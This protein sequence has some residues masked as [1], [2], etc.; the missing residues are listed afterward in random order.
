[1]PSPFPGMDPYLENSRLWRGTHNALIAFL[2]GQLNASLPQGFSASSEER[3]YAQPPGASY[4]PDDSL[5]QEFPLPATLSDDAYGGGETGNTAVIK[6]SAVTIPITTPRRVQVAPEQERE[7]FVEVESDETGEV[8]AVIEVLSPANKSNA[9]NGREEYLGKQTRL[10]ASPVHLLEIDLLRDGLFTVAV[11]RNTVLLQEKTLPPYIACLHKGG[12][13]DPTHTLDYWAMPLRNP[14]PVI[15]LP[16][17]EG[18]ADVPIDLQAVFATLYDA[19]PFA[20]RVDYREEPEPPLGA[21]DTAWADTL[22][23]TK[24]LR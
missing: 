5:R 2:T 22:L 3:V 7:M 14:L 1:M 15:G 6:R 17:T 24:G 11:P 21:D 23:R 18:F 12:Q 19:G 20:R 9:G 13:Y 16:L 4:Y 10:L 8:V